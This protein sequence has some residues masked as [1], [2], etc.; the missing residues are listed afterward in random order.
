MDT[1]TDIGIQ[2]NTDAD[3]GGADPG[4]G[5][6]HPVVRAKTQAERDLIDNAM[7][8]WR[9]VH[10]TVD[11]VTYTLVYDPAQV[12]M[13]VAWKHGMLSEGAQSRVYYWLSSVPLSIV[14]RCGEAEWAVTPDGLPEL[15]WAAAAATYLACLRDYGDRFAQTVGGELT[16][17]DLDGAL[18]DMGLWRPGGWYGVGD[19]PGPGGAEGEGEGEVSDAK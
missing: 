5:A 11:G 2:A 16:Y 9:T 4:A 18:H 12:T 15:P 8:H 19:G 1:D 6:E 14:A 13:E 10:A 17:I 3:P 7:L